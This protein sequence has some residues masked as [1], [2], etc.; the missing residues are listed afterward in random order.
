[1]GILTLRKVTI[2]RQLVVPSNSNDDD[3]SLVKHDAQ[4]DLNPGGARIHYT[5]E[6][7]FMSDLPLLSLPPYIVSG[8]QV[9]VGH[10]KVLIPNPKSKGKG[11]TE[12]TSL[13]PTPRVQ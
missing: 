7:A 2:R 10:G 6:P 8:Q 1:M 5:Q 4:V 11:C 3:L 9:G 12:S 13:N